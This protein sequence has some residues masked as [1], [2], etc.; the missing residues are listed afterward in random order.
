MNSLTFKIL[1]LSL[2]MMKFNF[3]SAQDGHALFSSCQNVKYLQKQA[4]DTQTAVFEAGYCLGVIY[5]VYATLL[6]VGKE[7]LCLPVLGLN[8]QEKVGIVN[9]YLKS[10]SSLLKN[11]DVLLILEAFKNKFPCHSTKK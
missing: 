2:I 3:S 9:E 6:K 7:N 4:I 5:G 11:E 1:F 10:H 8:N